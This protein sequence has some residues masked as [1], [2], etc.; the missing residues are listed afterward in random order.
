MCS[1]D[2]EREREREREIDRERGG[3]SMFVHVCDRMCVCL[4]DYNDMLHDQT[5]LYSLLDSS[6]FIL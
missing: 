4:C 6:F 3:V 1:S 2:L 5:Y